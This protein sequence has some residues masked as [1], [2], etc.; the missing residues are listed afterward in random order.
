MVTATSGCSTPTAS[1]TQP[2]AAEATTASEDVEEAPAAA[3]PADTPAESEPVTLVVAVPN[4]Y[5]ETFD[6]FNTSTTMDPHLMVY[7]TLVTVDYDYEYRP[8]LAESWDLSEDGLTWTFHLREGVKFHDGSDFTADVVEWWLEGMQQGVN[9]YMFESMTGA[10]VID[11][12]TIALSFP[13]PFPNLLY[14][15]ATSF[16]GIMSREAYEKYGDE[17]GTRYAIGTGPFMLEEWVPND[18]ILLVKNPDYNWAPEWMGHTGPANVDRILY[19][20][21]PEDATRSIELQAASTSRWAGCL[22][23]SWFSTRIIRTTSTSRDPR[24]PSSSSV[25]R[26]SS[27]CSAISAPAR[28]LGTRSIEI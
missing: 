22:P 1:P 27:L 2:P 18:H 26:S 16:S 20:I 15:L 4:Q 12:H 8:G 17:Y 24:P 13:A 25:C 3:E 19:R 9:S 28:P 23:G 14:N 10:E 11:E 5:G 7:E 6:V 21:I